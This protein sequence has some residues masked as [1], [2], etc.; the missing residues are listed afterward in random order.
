MSQRARREANDAKHWHE[1]A[2]MGFWWDDGEDITY[3]STEHG[4]RFDRPYHWQGRSP[5]VTDALQS[6]GYAPFKLSFSGNLER[7]SEPDEEVIVVVRSAQGMTLSDVVDAHRA[8]D[9]S[10]VSTTLGNQPAMR[11]ITTKGEEAV[12]TVFQSKEY[13]ILLKPLDA[14]ER[15]KPVFERAVQSFRFINRRLQSL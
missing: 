13:T 10:P 1:A 3:W 6:P 4:F 15:V 7:R 12:T 2:T 11:Y 5:T 8:A 14:G 9:S